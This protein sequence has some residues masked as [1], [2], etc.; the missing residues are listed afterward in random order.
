MTNVDA[1][2]SVDKIVRVVFNLYES[3]FF[4]LLA[5]EQAGIL[6]LFSRRPCVR[7]KDTHEFMPRQA[8]GRNKFAFRTFVHIVY[9]ERDSQSE[10]TELRTRGT[11]NP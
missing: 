2:I 5:P 11:I 10:I 6:N 3:E 4:I 7:I 8:I 9:D 1:D